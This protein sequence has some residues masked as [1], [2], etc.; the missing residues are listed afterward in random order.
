MPPAI[1]A[2]SVPVSY[3]NDQIIGAATGRWGEVAHEIK[4]ADPYHIQ[5]PG[6]DDIVISPMTR[7]R[8]KALK[9][10]Q[11]AYLM[12]GAQLAEAEKAGTADQGIISRIQGI[13]EEAE[14]AYDDALFGDAREAVYDYY[15]DLDEAFWDAMYTDVHAALVNRVDTPEDVCSKCGQEIKTGD[16]DKEP[17]AGK[18]DSSST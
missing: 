9:T 15:D 7:R 10:A 2:R 1:K 16:E 14:T 4:P 11:A 3:T 18:G 8:R 5:I 6:G 13:M 17:E 12:V